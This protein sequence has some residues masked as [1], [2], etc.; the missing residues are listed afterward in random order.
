MPILKEPRRN[1]GLNGTWPVETSYFAYFTPTGRAVLRDGFAFLITLF[2]WGNEKKNMN[3]LFEQFWDI[4][5][6][7]VAGDLYDVLW[8]KFEMMI[9]EDSTPELSLNNTKV[10]SKNPGWLDV[11]LILAKWDI[12]IKRTNLEPIVELLVNLLGKRIISLK[13]ILAGKEHSD[14]ET[15]IL[16]EQLALYKELESFLS[17]QL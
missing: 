4:H 5:T 6:E 2:I 7:N 15:S 3:E 14:E 17:C 8:H 16:I 12:P 1:A 10:M 13:N 11:C 9:E